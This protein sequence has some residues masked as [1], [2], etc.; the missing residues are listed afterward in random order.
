MHVAAVPSVESTLAEIRAG[1]GRITPARRAVLSAI[2]D[3][4]VHHYTAAEI[5]AAVEGA[6]SRP[7]RATV[8]RTLDLLVE[9]SVL[10]PL[11]LCGE[12]TIYHRSDRRHGHL[13]CTRCGAI[14]EVPEFFLRRIGDALAARTGFVVDTEQVAMRGA[15]RHCVTGGT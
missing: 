12:A 1:G 8:Y 9:L 3:A 11:Q 7:D 6:P 13:V 14:V 15:C 2:L 4:G 10:T 5:L